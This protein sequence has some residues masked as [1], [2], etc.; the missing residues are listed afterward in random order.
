METS[1]LVEI[2]SISPELAASCEPSF[3]ELVFA[4]GLE[5]V[6]PLADPPVAVGAVFHPISLDPVLLLVCVGV[7]LYLDHYLGLVPSAV[8]VAGF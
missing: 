8:L 5:S 3:L 2:D 1:Q 7:D 4:A 6:Q